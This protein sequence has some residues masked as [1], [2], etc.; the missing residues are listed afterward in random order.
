MNTFDRIME[1]LTEAVAHASG[2]DAPNMVVHVPASLDVSRIR[3][4]TSLSQPLFARSLGVSVATLRQWEQQR[5]KPEGPARVLLAMV[6]RNPKIVLE[7][8][9]SPA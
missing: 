1:G 5:R 2:N 3:A 6:D 8:L 4:K 7:T 9:G